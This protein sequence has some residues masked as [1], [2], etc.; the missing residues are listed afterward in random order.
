LYGAGTVGRG[1]RKPRAFRH[2]KEAPPVVVTL[3]TPKPP[4]TPMKVRTASMAWPDKVMA[5]GRWLVTVSSCKTGR[6]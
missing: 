2:R 4:P 5:E 1:N 6:T 3:A